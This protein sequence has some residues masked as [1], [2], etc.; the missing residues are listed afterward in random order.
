MATAPVKSQPLHNFSLPP[1]LKWGH[2]SHVNPN[3]RYRR[4]A[5]ATAERHR[6]PPQEQEEEQDSENGAGLENAKV[7][8]GSRREEGSEFAFAPCSSR[9]QEGTVL[10]GEALEVQAE[11]S[12][13][14]PW[15]LRPRR[16]V[17]KAAVEIGGVSRNGES[18]EKAPKVS[19]STALEETENLPKSM[20][21]RGYSEG[22]G[23][24]RREKRRLWIAL[25]REEIEEDVFSMTGSRPA[26]R[27]KRR[28]KT[29]QKQLDNIFPGLYLA[30]ATA[31]S[32]RVYIAPK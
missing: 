12:A 1:L 8:I 22:Q 10:E 14:K 9:R 17:V 13:T 11:E 29:V 5:D 30:G 2:K 24:E 25:S 6:S 3:H 27:P 15:N 31:D 20:R 32:Y 7:A 16:P 18:E 19:E 28:P 21:L 4:P 26:R 23:L